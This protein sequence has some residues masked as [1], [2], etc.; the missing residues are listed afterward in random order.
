[1]ANEKKDN[2]EEAKGD[3]EKAVEIGFNYSAVKTNLS[4]E[5]VSQNKT[6][7]VKWYRK[8]AAPGACPGAGV[9]EN[10]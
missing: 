8:A 10:Y 9:A 4:V 1:M 2:P 6:E 5:G 3:F 7:A